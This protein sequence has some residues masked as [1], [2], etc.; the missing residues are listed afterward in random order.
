MRLQKYLLSTK[1]NDD[2]MRR[3]VH[4]RDDVDD[5]G[6]V[7][8]LHPLLQWDMAA[9]TWLVQQKEVCSTTSD[10]V[11]A[12]DVTHQVCHHVGTSMAADVGARHDIS[13]SNAGH[14]VA[15]MVRMFC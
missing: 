10:F 15:S 5:D 8:E 9:V 7:V 13:T 4:F 11:G 14:F 1:Q 3:R 12:C 2:T 6:E